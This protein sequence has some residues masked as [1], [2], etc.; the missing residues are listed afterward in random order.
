MITLI[1]LTILISLTT[2]RTC[3]HPD[4]SV[5]TSNVPYTSDST[6]FCCDS[7]AICMTNGYCI[8]V[9]SQP[10]L[11]FRGSCT[12]EDWGDDCPSHC[13]NK[14]PSGGAPII[15]IGSDSSGDAQYC[16]GFQ[17]KNNGTSECVDGD[18]AFT[19]D[20]GEMILGRAALENVTSTTASSSST[21]STAL[22]TSATT[23]TNTASYSASDNDGTHCSGGSNATAVGAGV[24]VPLGV[25]AVS[26]AVWALWERGR[27]RVAVAAAAAAAGAGGGYVMESHQGGLGGMQNGWKMETAPLAELGNGRP[28]GVQEMMG[29]G[30]YHRS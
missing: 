24:G 17:V 8:G 12:D 30:G 9:G 11:L 23:V 18:T 22:G 2:A 3:Y 26:A 4:K 10:Y 28:D 7:G 15:G 5:A 6:T 19:L 14:N 16:C 29:S 13:V 25:L 21:S 27:R 20:D 1:P